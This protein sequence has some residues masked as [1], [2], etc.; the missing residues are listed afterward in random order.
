MHPQ[1]GLRTDIKLRTLSDG[2][3]HI[4]TMPHAQPLVNPVSFPS[5]PLSSLRCTHALDCTTN[6][7][8]VTLGLSETVL[9]LSKTPSERHSLVEAEL[10]S[11]LPEAEFV[12]RQTH[13]VTDDNGLF[14]GLLSL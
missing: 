1:H 13:V 10:M 2:S 4:E 9:V 14:R 11:C 7:F 12:L 8:L 5:V 6:M 3:L